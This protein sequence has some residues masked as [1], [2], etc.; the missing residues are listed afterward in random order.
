MN[1]MSPGTCQVKRG[2]MR[3]FQQHHR[4]VVEL[5]MSSLDCAS[6]VGHSCE[7]LLAYVVS[8]IFVAVK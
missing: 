8:H 2:F 3:D 7:R 5:M 1:H 6:Q 4:I